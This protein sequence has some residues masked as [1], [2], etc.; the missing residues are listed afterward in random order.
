[1]IWSGAMM[2][3]FLG[4]GSGAARDAH[5]AIVAAIEEVLTRGPHTPDLGG[6]ASTTQMG[7]AIAERVAERS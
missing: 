2:L 6:D 4:R 1:M 3:D 5:D 7:R